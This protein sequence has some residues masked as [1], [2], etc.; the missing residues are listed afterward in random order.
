MTAIRTIFAVA[1]LALAT[2]AAWKKRVLGRRDFAP[3][4]NS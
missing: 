1:L 4:C 3:R 2:P